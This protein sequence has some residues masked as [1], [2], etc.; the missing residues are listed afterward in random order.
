MHMPLN[1]KHIRPLVLHPLLSVVC[2]GAS[3][4]G[5]TDGGGSVEASSSVMVSCLAAKTSVA[6][7]VAGSET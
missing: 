1:V 4:I 2:C 7:V 6:A 5:V 3:W